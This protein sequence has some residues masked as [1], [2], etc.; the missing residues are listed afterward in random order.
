M[1][2]WK[3]LKSSTALS[4]V[5]ILNLQQPPL[6]T[7]RISKPFYST[8]TQLHDIHCLIISTEQASSS[9]TVADEVCD[10]NYSTR[11]LAQCSGIF[12]YTCK[13]MTYSSS[14]NSISLR[15]HEIQVIYKLKRTQKISVLASV[16][17]L[18]FLNPSPKACIMREV[19]IEENSKMIIVLKRMRW[20]HLSKSSHPLLD[21]C[22]TEAD[23]NTAS[24]ESEHVTGLEPI[25]VE[26]DHP[27]GFPSHLQICVAK[28]CN[29]M[30]N[31]KQ[32]R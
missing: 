2:H 16:T 24:L 17:H 7:L 21:I 27:V 26:Q 6:L 3:Y 11:Y 14:Q 9:S 10:T 22:K 4:D 29:L 32:V 13:N 30:A 23:N 25:G 28:Y 1:V 20:V 15:I 12:H 8:S 31:R 18:D 5:I 19:A